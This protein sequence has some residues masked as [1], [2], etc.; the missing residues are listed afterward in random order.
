MYVSLTKRHN[1]NNQQQNLKQQNQKNT[2]A[3]GQTH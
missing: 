3:N 2:A 1:H